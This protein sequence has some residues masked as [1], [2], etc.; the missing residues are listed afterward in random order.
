MSLFLI[1]SGNFYKSKTRNIMTELCYERWFT[2]ANYDKVLMKQTKNQNV[3]TVVQGKSLIPIQNTLL[4]RSCLLFNFLALQDPWWLLYVH[5]KSSSS[6][7]W[8]WQC[9]KPWVFKQY[10]LGLFHWGCNAAKM[11]QCSQNV[12]M[13]PKCYN[14]SKMLQCSQIFP[15]Q[16]LCEMTPCSGLH[17]IAC[18]L[19]YESWQTLQWLLSESVLLQWFCEINS[20]LPLVCYTM[21]SHMNKQNNNTTIV[22]QYCPCSFLHNSS[23]NVSCTYDLLWDSS[24]NVLRVNLTLTQLRFKLRT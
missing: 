10:L 24:D 12:T 18:F 4:T 8:A 3:L 17:L 2:T 6:Y 14:A 21:T 22:K 11:L 5:F 15:V 13:Q 23:R 1:C 19:L 16:W 9:P 20:F 7:Y